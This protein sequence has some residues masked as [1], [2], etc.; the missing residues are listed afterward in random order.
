MYVLGFL[1]AWCLGILRA[2]KSNG[3]WT[4]TQVAD[5]VFYAAVGGILGGRIGYVFLYDLNMFL[6][7]PLFI[8]KVWQ[9]G[10]SIHGGIIGGMIGL[11]I[12]SLR[13][14]KS[15]FAV[16]DFAVPLLPIGLCMGRIGNFI[17]G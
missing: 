6:A 16:T 9:G 2:R 4:T 12:Y 14:N 15:F 5:L 8:F 11:W 10:M 7:N 17:N 1:A 13:I 3:E